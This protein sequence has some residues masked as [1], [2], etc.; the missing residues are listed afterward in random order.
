MKQKVKGKFFKKKTTVLKAV[1]NVSFQIEKGEI[2]AFIGP[3]GAGKST[4][5]KML[6]GIIRPTRGDI[7]ISGLEPGSD[8]KKLAYRIGCMFGQKSQLYMHLSVIDSFRLLGSIYDL[9]K[10]ETDHRISEISEMFQIT[11]LLDKTVRKLS[12]GQ[13]MI[14]EIAGSILHDPDIIFLDEPTIGLDIVAKLRIREIILKLN[15]EK[16]TTIFLTSHD[17]SDVEVLCNRIIVI[18]NGII[19]KD[20]SMDTLKQEYLSKKRVTIYYERKLEVTWKLIYDVIGIEE[21][22]IILNVDTNKSH[23][24]EVLS[25]FSSLGNIADIQIDSTPMEDI[26]K[27]MYEERKK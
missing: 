15:K 14:C 17:V 25:Y 12:L 20:T 5:I 22:K 2:V 23:I 16:G 21:N 13:R 18:N 9:S 8:R 11:H 19:V 26:I 3:N 4:T 1:D 27:M 10:E 24:G 7:T 6:T